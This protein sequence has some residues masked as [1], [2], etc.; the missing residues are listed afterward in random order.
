MFFTA[1]WSIAEIPRLYGALLKT[2][3]SQRKKT[4]ALVIDQNH[5][6]ANKSNYSKKYCV[7]VRLVFF[8]F[9]PLKGKQKK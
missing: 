4:Y 2:Q 5:S 1:R 8:V 6:G 9:L 3:G 7:A